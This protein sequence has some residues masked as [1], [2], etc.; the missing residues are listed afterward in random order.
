MNSFTTRFIIRSTVV[1]FI[2]FITIYILF[3]RV[4]TDFIRAT[5]EADLVVQ[6]R[7]DFAR[8]II[9]YNRG[10]RPTP[11]EFATRTFLDLPDETFTI[12]SL[13]LAILSDD[14]FDNYII[15]NHRNHVAIPVVDDNIS[16]KFDFLVTYYMENPEIFDVNDTTSVDFNGDTFYLRSIATDY[17]EE[18]DEIIQIFP[19]P[20]YPLTIL[21]YTE[22][23][24][25]V[26][27]QNT[28]NQILLVALSISGLIILT[29]TARMSSRFK[30]SIN[31]LAHYAEAIGHGSFDSEIEEF[32]Y[33]EFQTLAKSMTDMSNMLESFEVNQ[34]KFFQ[35]ASH[36]LRTPLMAIQCYNEG[37]LADVFEPEDAADIISQEVEKMTELVNSILYLSR[38]TYTTSQNDPFSVNSFLTS[39]YEQIK[40]LAKN[41]NKNIH[42]N[43]LAED[44][45]INVD[46]QLL[47]RALLNI[48][49]NALRYVKTEISITADMR[50][51][52]DIYA[53]RKQN[54]LNVKIVNDG[55]KIA[56]KDLPHLFDR[57]YKGRGGNT[58]LGLAITKEIITS[59][60]GNVTAENLEDEDGV[61]F[62]IELP[63]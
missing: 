13:A 11:I 40:I 33:S 39:C 57:F 59:F 46:Y 15:I 16:E 48:L 45:Q 29:M 35:N 2:I 47:E 17:V 31:K 1:I 9:I 4:A 6:I 14:L 49:T 8:E 27:F 58:G 28:I 37:V 5:A 53:N 62:T 22:V 24:E 21:L 20:P 63:V 23:T 61:C 41:D 38:I 36:E 30:Q 32:K 3:N 12:D 43:P 42:F 56:E 50:I 18:L 51:S 26:A 19:P 25:M 60:S 10:W 55:E 52:R 7:N 54:L 44:V 34:K